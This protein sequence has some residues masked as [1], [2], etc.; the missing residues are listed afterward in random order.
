MWAH[1]LF[2]G[3]TLWEHGAMTEASQDHTFATR[4][5]IP[6]RMWDAY[7]RITARQ[8]TDRTAD[9]VAHVRTVIERDGDPADLADL[10]AA[11]RELTERRSRKGGRPPKAKPE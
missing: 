3:K 5:R 7:G 8:G 1:K 11:D 9:L 4:F 6:R 10:A 2:D